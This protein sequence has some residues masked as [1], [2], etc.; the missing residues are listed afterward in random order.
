MG[1]WP[2]K[3]Q[4]ALPPANAVGATASVAM[5][6]APVE[7]HRDGR[8]FEQVSQVQHA[9]PSCGG[10]GVKTRTT[11]LMTSPRLGGGLMSADC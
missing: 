9:A 6:V 7:Q 5:S 2:W 4:P 11:D 1:A 3:W 8:E 10:Q